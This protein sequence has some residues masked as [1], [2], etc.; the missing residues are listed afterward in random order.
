MPHRLVFRD[1]KISTNIRIDFDASSKE[2]NKS[3]NDCLCSGS[4]LNRNLLDII[5]NLRKLNT[6][7]CA[8]IK[9]A[10]LPISIAEEDRKYLKF[11]WL[12][13]DAKIFFRILRF[14]RVPFGVS[15]SSFILAATIKHHIKK[16]L[17]P[18]SKYCKNV[19]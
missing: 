14:R 3:L 13:N 17:R 1:N 18:A 5:I 10:F 19:R 16:F 4:D 7:F 11:L 6:A 8:D 2:N 9:K 15:C 12:D